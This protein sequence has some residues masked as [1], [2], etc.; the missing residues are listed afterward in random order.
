MPERIRGR[1]GPAASADVGVWWD[2]MSIVPA[3]V[4]RSRYGLADPTELDDEERHV[5]GVQHHPDPDRRRRHAPGPDRLGRDGFLR[6]VPGSPDTAVDVD[7]DPLHAR[8]REHLHVPLDP[9]RL[10]D[11]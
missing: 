9:A 1:A 6:A 10:G 11:R 7:P 5:A 4:E 3:A 2:M 8:R